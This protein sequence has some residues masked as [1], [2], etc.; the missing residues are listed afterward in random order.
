MFC[1]A[2]MIDVKDVAVQFAMALFFMSRTNNMQERASK[3]V[4][5]RMFDLSNMDCICSVACMIFA[6]GVDVACAMAL[7]CMCKNNNISI[8]IAMDCFVHDRC[9]RCCCTIRDGSFLHV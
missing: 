2:Y 8:G 7:C 6:H 9:Q 3:C 1:V 4:C 5:L